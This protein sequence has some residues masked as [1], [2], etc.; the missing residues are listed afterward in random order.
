MRRLET[1]ALVALVV[2]LCVG[3]WPLESW[4]QP[5]DPVE[6]VEA[7]LTDFLRVFENG[8]VDAMEAAFADATVFPR[9]IM[10]GEPAE[11]IRVAV[12]RRQ[13]GLDPQMREVVAEWRASRPGP[14]YLVL[15]P[16]DLEIEVFGDA[17]LA[18]FHLVNGSSL[19]RRTFVLALRDGDW[20]IVHLHASNVIGSN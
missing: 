2:V 4:A 13:R 18:T 14:P 11:P 8:E 20:R 7:V 1:Q 6:E 19:S 16:R 17:A 9:A 12:Y 3:L 10:G 5:S 15:E